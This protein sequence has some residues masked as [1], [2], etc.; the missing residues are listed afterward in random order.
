ME[1]TLEEAAF[2]T[3]KNI[4]VPIA[5]ICETCHGSRTD[6]SSKN[7][8][9]ATCNGT[10]EIRRTRN[11]GFTVLTQVENC[12]SCS[13]IGI[14][15]SSLCKKCRGTGYIRRRK[16]IRINIPSGISSETSLRLS[17]KGEPGTRGGPRG[18]LYVIIHVKPHKL[19]LRDGDNIYCDAYIGMVESTL[20]TEI[21]VPT[22][23]DKVKLKIPSGT[24]TGTVLRL[25]GKG[26]P[27]LNSWGK[28]NLYV[29]I[30][31]K[32]P[33]NLTKKQKELLKK[34]GKE[35]NEE[36]D[37]SKPKFDNS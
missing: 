19:F 8:K 26:I 36:V 34:L 6:P 37:F 29:R 10:G 15:T 25:K 31:I 30:K 18:D 24:Q 22:L 20:G 7:T 13:G 14:P 4:N 35:L 1:I 23:K 5:D 11:M 27:H 16:N 2:G 12:S 3:D 17:G 32:T 28:G 21:I 9:C 33:K